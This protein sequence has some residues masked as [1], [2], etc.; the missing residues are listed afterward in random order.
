MEATT[1]RAWAETIS[2]PAADTRSH[3]SITTPLSSTR[4]M[5]STRL[6]DSETRSMVIDR[7][8]PYTPRQRVRG[9]SAAITPIGA[10]PWRFN[11]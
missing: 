4:S 2:I 11:R 3:A 9:N 5:I 6:E 10:K 7:Q 8:R 1:T